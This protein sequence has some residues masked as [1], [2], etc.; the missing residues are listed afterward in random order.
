MIQSGFRTTLPNL[1]MI[2]LATTLEGGIKIEP[3][4]SS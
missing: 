4:G 2:V 3:K 1:P